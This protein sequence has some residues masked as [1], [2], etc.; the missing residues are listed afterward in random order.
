MNDPYKIL[1]ISPNASD[2]EVKT[3]YRKLAKK[4][5]PDNYTGSP[6]SDLAGEKMKE[7]NYAYDTIVNERRKRKNSGNRGYAGYT[8]S[9]QSNGKYNYLRQ[10]ILNG[11]LN[12]AQRILE[13]VSIDQRDAEWYFMFGTVLYK[14]GWLEEAYSNFVRAHNMEPSNGEYREAIERMNMQRSG[15]YGGYTRNLGNMSG[16][17][18]CNVCTSLICMDCCCE[19]LGGDFIRCC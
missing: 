4:Y 16:C 11:R 13:G 2:E 7:I 14:R 1:G 10:M 15:Y 8:G 17:S 3:A 9:G 19:C 6:L 12:E 5:H 18:G